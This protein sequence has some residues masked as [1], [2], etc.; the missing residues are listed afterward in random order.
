MVPPQFE[1][2]V[3]GWRGCSVRPVRTY[4]EIAAIL[5]ERRGAPIS[6]ARVRR[7]CRT[8]EAKVVR[9]LLADPE[10]SRL[11]RSRGARR[12]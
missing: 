9:G 11:M 1:G 3:L 2:N 10:L 4:R 7:V 8:A 12:G 5:G 6:P